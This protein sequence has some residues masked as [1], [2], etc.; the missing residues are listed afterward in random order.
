MKRILPL[1]LLALLTSV[2]SFAVDV[3][4]LFSTSDST[5]IQFAKANVSLLNHALYEDSVATEWSWI[6]ENYGTQQ[7]AWSCNLLSNYS[8]E[9]IENTDYASLAEIPSDKGGDWGVNIADEYAQT[10]RTPTYEE[11]DYILNKRANATDRRCQLYVDQEYYGYVLFPDEP[12]KELQYYVSLISDGALH[13]TGNEMS[14][15]YEKEAVILPFNSNLNGERAFF[16]TSTGYDTSSERGDAPYS[17]AMA[18][19][20]S[21]QTGATIECIS[22]DYKSYVRLVRSVYKVTAVPN[23]TERGETAVGYS[24][25]EPINI[26][27]QPKAGYEFYAVYGGSVDDGLMK[28]DSVAGDTEVIAYYR[29]EAKKYIFPEGRQGQLMMQSNET[30]LV[31]YENWDYDEQS[32]SYT[33]KMISVAPGEWGNASYNWLVLGLGDVVKMYVESELTFEENSHHNDDDEGEPTTQTFAY[34]FKNWRI[35]GN[36]GQDVDFISAEQLT[37]TILTLNIDANMPDTMYVMAEYAEKTHVSS[38]QSLETLLNNLS[39]Y[40]SEYENPTSIVLEDSITTRHNVAEMSVNFLESVIPSSLHMLSTVGGRYTGEFIATDAEISDLI[41][42]MKGGLF[43][44]IDSG[45]VVQDLYFDNTAIYITAADTANWTVRGDTL[46]VDILASQVGG[47]V[48]GF[49]LAGHVIVSDELSAKYP[50]II[51]CIIGELKPTGKVNGFYYNYRADENTKAVRLREVQPI[52]LDN[53]NKSGGSCKMASTYADFGV[54]SGINGYI[55]SNEELT[56]TSRLFT[57]DEFACGVVAYWLNYSGAGYTGDYTA[58]WRQGPQYP[59]LARSADEALYGIDYT[60]DEKDADNITKAP[61]F[62]NAGDEVT[63]EY[64]MKPTQILVDGEE[65][66]LGDA[67]ATFTMTAGNKHVV[68]SFEKPTAVSTITA[69]KGKRGDIY[70]LQGTKVANPSRGLYIQDGHLVIIK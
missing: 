18:L 3:T 46:F 68:I 21:S 16:W 69:D 48:E 6:L 34:E 54:K 60:C 50:H 55:Y 32:G 57:V 59:V 8:S 24:Y 2:R 64:A 19:G 41:V 66:T 1:A 9:S 70:T 36:N 43:E 20:I 45:A 65:I 5:K 52:R 63:I 33:S 31:T 7:F 38:I 13:L 53:G 35:V 12:S 47:S 28:I 29:N 42:Q 14:A 30:A 22:R 67:S 49:A 56:K 40:S 10:W 37:D 62:V 11:F 58:K 27:P 4:A 61:R 51:L 23:M 15:F 44:N 25:G 17:T 39:N 26:E